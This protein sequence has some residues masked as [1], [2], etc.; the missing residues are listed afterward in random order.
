MVA[1]ALA[2]GM[3]SA[4]TGLVAYCLALD[5]APVW[6]GDERGLAGDGLFFV[7]FYALLAA[8]LGG[9]ARLGL[10]LTVPLLVLFPLGSGGIGY[11]LRF[12]YA[13]RRSGVEKAVYVLVLSAV[14]ASL[15]WIDLTG[16]VSEGGWL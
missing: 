3:L 15:P 2:L 9:I 8:A 11:G 5:P 12:L 10:G 1:D 16:R 14:I 7:P 6:S 13:S 4:G